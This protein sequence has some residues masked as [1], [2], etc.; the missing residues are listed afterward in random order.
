MGNWYQYLYGFLVPYST[1]VFQF[2][3][4]HEIQRE[5]QYK[6]KNRN[7]SIIKKRIELELE[8]I[9]WSWDL[10]ELESEIE[11]LMFI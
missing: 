8:R 11:L 2:T 3:L 6:I 9:V 5:I 7:N 4:F 1:D 10:W